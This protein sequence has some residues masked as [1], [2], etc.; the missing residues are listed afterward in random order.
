[1]FLSIVSGLQQWAM[2]IQK[3][4]TH[5]MDHS[6]SAGL[7]HHAGFCDRDWLLLV[8]GAERLN[9]IFGLFDDWPGE[10]ARTAYSHAA[11][12]TFYRPARVVYSASALINPRVSW[13]N[14][15][16]EPFC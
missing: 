4:L 15:L 16:S 6:V 8:K 13:R 14:V 1:M 7:L 5:K 3:I 11:S 10:L 12:E 9:H 2:Q